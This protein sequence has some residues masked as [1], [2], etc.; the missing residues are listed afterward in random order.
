MIW[1]RAADLALQVTED[2]VGPAAMVEGF[3][4]R[5]S[6][7][8]LCVTTSTAGATMVHGFLRS[9]ALK[10]VYN[11]GGAVAVI[12]DGFAFAADGSLCT[13]AADPGLP[14]HH[15]LKFDSAGRVYAVVLV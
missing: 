11:V 8:A 7:G 1:P 3:C 14:L 6:D 10:L 15:G 12:H 5:V 13:A 2:A 4:R 9:P